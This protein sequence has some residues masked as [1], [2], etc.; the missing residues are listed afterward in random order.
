MQEF[1]ENYRANV[2]FM[3]HELRP[4]E[5]F[6]ILTRTLKIGDEEL[7]FFF[8]D[9][10]VK[11]AQLGKL[12]MHFLSLPHAGSADNLVRNLPQ[13]EVDLCEDAEL[14]LTAVLSGQTAIFGTNF[15]KKCIL[16][17]LRTY[18]ARGV[19][20]PEGDRVMQGSR[21]GFTETLV[22]NTALLRRRVRDTRLTMEYYNLGGTSKTDVVICYL[23]GVADESY[24][25]E[26]SRQIASL[27]PKSLTMGFQS[28]AE[29][30][31][32]SRW[33]NPFPKIRTTERPDTAAAQVVEGSVLVFCD[34]SPQ[35]MILPT[36]LF[37][38]LQQTDDYYYPPLTG[39]YLRLVRTFILLLS[40]V[41]TPL[42][43][44]S[45]EYAAVLPPWL[46]FLIPKEPGALPII[47][48]LFLAE[49]AIDGLKIAS[50]NTPDM[51][52]NSL[53]VVGA[54]IL[55]DFAITVGWFCV[56]V[57]LYMAFVAIA[58]F[59]QQNHELGYAFKFMRML[60]LGLTAALGIW[61]FALGCVLFC[62][63]AATVKGVGH[64]RSYLYPLIPWNG[65]AM[66][67]LLFRTRK[68][69]FDSPAAGRTQKP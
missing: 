10:F 32:R 42:W 26:L 55:G 49:L 60:I 30:L 18:P 11:D 36:S 67:R 46:G 56:D 4:K 14:A 52:S 50:M 66:R 15:G 61:G 57:I 45:L 69:D 43:Y 51:L 33:Y 27:R 48:Q 63:F 21:D 23:K 54:L 8:I 64:G 38:Y 34:T 31:I 17:D 25:M 24:V 6:D 58:N 39:T 29:T 1:Y 65:K 16:V 40:V 12:M 28:L 68:K 2:E 13:I 47:L 19:Q 41:A 35:V 62:F 7:S 5:N 53:S 22:V 44:L 9:G 3:E 37:D 59:A 20:E